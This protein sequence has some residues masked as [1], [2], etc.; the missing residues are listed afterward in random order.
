MALRNVEFSVP[1]RTWRDFRQSLLET[2]SHHEEVIGFIFCTRYAQSKGFL[3][4]LP[5]FWVVPEA[6]SYDHQSIGGLELSQDVHLYLL[7]KFIRRGLDV[8]HIH[9]HPCVDPAHFSSIDDAHE[10]RYARFLASLPNRPLLVSGV[11]DEMLRYPNFRL[12]SPSGEVAKTSVSFSC[13]ILAHRHRVPVRRSVESLHVMSKT[14]ERQRIFGESFQRQLSAMRIGLVGCGGIGSIFAEQLSRLGVKDWVLVDPDQIE[15]SNLNRM[16]FST[17]RMAEAGR[18]KTAYVKSLIKRMWPK[19]SR[20]CAESNALGDRRSERLLRSC[21]LVV[22]ATDNHA[23]RMELQ[24]LALKFVLP[25]LS[26]ATHID[27]AQAGGPRI[28]SRI[29]MPPVDGGWCLVCGEV[30]DPNEAAVENAPEQLLAPVRE[31][32]YLSDVAAP[33]VYWLNGLAA[34]MAVSVVHRILV[35]Q[36][37]DFKGVDWILDLTSEHWIKVEHEESPNCYYC[38][39]EGL[40]ATGDSLDE[41]HVDVIRIAGNDSA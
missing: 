20:V 24:E 16:P 40:Y 27:I 10:A 12:W 41:N 21:D 36:E 39:S 25:L 37:S 9:T 17:L 3:R 30:V 22:V 34:S 6:D 11:F 32:G 2:R 19:G 14:L 4:L 23:S 29:T 5:R 33:A 15:V 7:D 8:V 13:G 28:F 31:H 26:I 38:S 1:A 35:N 18:L